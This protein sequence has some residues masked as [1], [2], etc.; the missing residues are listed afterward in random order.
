MEQDLH[1]DLM[2]PMDFPSIELPEVP[3]VVSG[4]KYVIRKASSDVGRKYRSMSA[5]CVKMTDGEMSG[6]D[7]IGDVQPFLLSLCLYQVT[8]D[9]GRAPVPIG[10]INCWPDDIVTPLFERA[11]K[12][13]NLQEAETTDTL[14]KS[15]AKMQ[16]R[17]DKMR[18]TPKVKVEEAAKNELSPT[19]GGSA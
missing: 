11:R 17:L 10:T 7:G 4:H 9:G 15:I 13:G 6:I 18:G 12:L 16:K 19:T 14:E 5:R 1:F 3:V 8:D 2:S